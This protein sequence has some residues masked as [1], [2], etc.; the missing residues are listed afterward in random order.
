MQSFNRLLSILAVIIPLAIS[1]CNNKQS[2]ASQEQTQPSNS[3]ISSNSS[4]EKESGVPLSNYIPYLKDLKEED[5]ESVSYQIEKHEF[6]GQYSFCD[7]LQN[8]KS[9]GQEDIHRVYE[10]LYKVRVHEYIGDNKERSQ[11]HEAITFTIHLKTEEERLECVAF[12]CSVSGFYSGTA[13]YNF[14]SLP[15]NISSY[16]LLSLPLPTFT[17]FVGY[18]YNPRITEGLSA[19]NRMTKSYALVGNIKALANVIFVKDD[20]IPSEDQYN[21]Y[22]KY[23]FSNRSY[24]CLIF[25]NSKQFRVTHDSSWQGDYGH[26]TIIND[27]SFE[28][29]DLDFQNL[30]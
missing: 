22:N 8:Y 15:S 4:S 23:L 19:F 7:P 24:G 20:F 16:T 30:V 5:I 3:S 1:S 27:V 28:T 10:Y 14:K 12:G 21:D 6:E 29:L 11:S 26:Y 9:N 2:N 13:S 18:S 25:E 17:N